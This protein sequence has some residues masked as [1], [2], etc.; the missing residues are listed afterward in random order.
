MI[1]AIRAIDRRGH[2]RRRAPALSAPSRRLREGERH[3]RPSFEARRHPRPPTST[4][5]T[6]PPPTS[7][8]SA[9]APGGR[10]RAGNHVLCEKPLAP[11]PRR[12]AL[13]GRRLQQ[14]GVVMGTNHH[15][16][17]AAGSHRAMRDAIEAGKIGKPI[18]RP[19]LPRR[20]P[21]AAPAGLAHHKDA[22]G[23]LRRGDSTSPCTTPT[24]LR[25]VRRTMPVAGH[26]LHQQGRHGRA[27]IG[28]GVMCMLALR[29]RG[30][31]AS[32]HDGFTTTISP[33]PASRCTAAKA[34]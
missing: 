25:F 3:S 33:A 32:S 26:G 29:E 11:H 1:D 28:D 14:A 20:L 17:N 27:G 16:R 21:A 31:L 24:A 18:V 34:R 12:C 10:R 7:C 23:R 5:S 13:D 9:Q 19:R 30:S 4:P 6:S 8:I 2:G 15:L 22:E